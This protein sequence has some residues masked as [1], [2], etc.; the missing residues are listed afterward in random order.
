MEFVAKNAHVL[1]MAPSVSQ[2]AAAKCTASI[3]ILAAN[4]NL[5][6]NAI[7]KNA[8]VISIFDNVTPISVLGAVDI[9]T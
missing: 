6:M 2:N 1:S 3:S 9:K 5:R 7:S 8:T 4:A